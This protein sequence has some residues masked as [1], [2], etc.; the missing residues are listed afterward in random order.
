MKD[1][2]GAVRAWTTVCALAIAA[3]P[4]SAHAQQ[5][6]GQLTVPELEDE[7]S[8]LPWR[9]TSFT[10]SQSLNAAALSQ[11]AQLS[12]D[13]TYSWAFIL[14]P[15]WYFNKTT[16]VSIDQRLLLELTDSDTTLH[17]QRALLSDTVL[18][19]D[20]RLLEGKYPRF[21]SLAVIGGEALVA[22]TSLSSQAS[23]MVVGARLRA[24]AQLDF[25]HVLKG[26]SVALQ[27][28][29]LHRFLRDNV[30]QVEAPYPCLTGGLAAQSC[31]ALDST[32]NVENALSSILSGALAVTDQLTIELLV[33][34]TWSRGSNLADASVITQSGLP[35][36]LPDDSTTHWRNDRY[37]V[38]GA[39]W[40]INDWL[41]LGLSVIDYFSERNPDGSLRSP[42]KPID[43]LIGLSTSISFD[44]LY[45]ATLGRRPD[46]TMH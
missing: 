16:Y 29:Y 8:S 1:V 7:S 4:S 32:T 23:T 38:L 33:W 28:R 15:R 27:G 34:F 20:T 12:Y 42:G 41:Q 11:S 6:T 13:P 26:L 17:R 46:M 2:T 44:K 25:K 35:V 39:D 31:D 45:L 24:G 3:L 37:I 22:P 9:G 19:L 30:L 21:G 36:D 40:N 43:L 10:F 18:A 14:E 5:R